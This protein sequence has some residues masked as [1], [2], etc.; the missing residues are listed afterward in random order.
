VVLASHRFMAVHRRDHDSS[1]GGDEMTQEDLFSIDQPSVKLRTNARPAEQQ[2]ARKAVGRA[3]SWRRRIFNIVRWDGT[4]TSK[5]IAR[6]LAEQT[7]CEDCGCT[8]RP[9]IPVNQI[10]SRLQ[11]LRE[12]GFLTHLYEGSEIVLRDGAE[13]HVLTYKG[14]ADG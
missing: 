13:V 5:E 9:P 8:H 2:A 14:Q 12:W 1:V 10:A 11:E 6:I 7:P 4:S 3:G